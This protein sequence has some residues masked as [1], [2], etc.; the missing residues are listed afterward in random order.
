[1]TT[2]DTTHGVTS[3]EPSPPSE[4]EYRQDITVAFHYPVVFTHGVF[5]PANPVLERAM[6]GA[7]TRRQH[8]AM[9][10]LDA[11]VAAAR[12][13]L[14]GEIEAYFAAHVSTL[15]LAAAPRM[16][17]GGERAKSGWS[18]VQSIITDIAAHKLC[19]HS[20]VLA[21]GGGSMLDMVGFAA[22]LVH[23]GLRL[24]R[25]PTTV[26]AQNDGGVGVKTGLNEH[27]SKNFIGTF[28]PPHAV[29]DDF[30]FL[31]T[32]PERDWTGGIAEAFK[33][34]IIR[35]AAFLDYLF[36]RA[37]ALR[38][39]DMGCMEYLVRR[40]AELHLDHIREGGDPFETGTARP[41]DFGHWSAHRLE[42]LSDYTLGHGQAVAIGVALGSLYAAHGGFIATDAAWR[43]V[44][45]LQRSGLPVWHTLLERRDAAGRLAVIE[46]L[47][48]FREHLGG[49]LTV[50]LPNGLG[51]K[52]EVN[53][54]DTALIESCIAELH[55]H[56][57][58][59]TPC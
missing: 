47:D 13:A 5:N 32:L 15:H 19:R 55:A 46:G 25:L 39:R 16:L 22:S 57:V 42:V 38:R 36:A 37:E 28:A 26:L 30:D 45:G 48:Q 52:Q 53:S 21:I 44:R 17:E 31:A 43:I 7:D 56:V 24:V 23:R 10:F 54:M 20:Y 9:V 33:V 35:D 50:T 40:C 6:A 58:E 3:R 4:G 2:L 41:L 18:R 1:M 34:A 11:G 59:S 27:G 51:R 12:P 29:I 14:A 49:E 8:R